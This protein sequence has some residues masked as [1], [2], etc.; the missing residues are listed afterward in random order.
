MHFAFIPYGKRSE[1]ELFLR[2][3]DA[4]KHKLL[5]TDPDGKQLYI[6]IQ[7]SVRQLPFGV[8]EYVFPKEDL[9]VVL[10][11]M[12]AEQ[13]RYEVPGWILTGFRK[14]LRLKKLPTYGKEHNYLWIKDN[15]NIISIGYKFDGEIVEPDHSKYPGCK[16]EA[17]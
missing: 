1:V 12:L 17:L 8:Y 4:Q 2:D 9:D 14:F 15:V 10:N 16:H 3:M 7:G 6:W 5:M 11:T 13:N